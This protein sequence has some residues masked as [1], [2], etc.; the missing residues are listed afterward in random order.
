[1]SHRPLTPVVATP[2]RVREHSGADP[3][4]RL[5]GLV[6]SVVCGA[7]QAANAHD[8]A[9]FVECFS[10]DGVVD[11]WGVLFEAGPAVELWAQRWVVDHGVRF[12]DLLHAVDDTSVAVHCQVH[13]SGYSGPATLTFTVL[14]NVIGLLRIRR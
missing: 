10:V 5:A 4:L 9:T 3:T 6:P 12:T 11:A 14:G 8:V 2:V 1:M 7:I 13:G